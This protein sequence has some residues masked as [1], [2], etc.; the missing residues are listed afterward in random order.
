LEFILA[1][2]E[3]LKNIHFY[4]IDIEKKIDVGPDGSGDGV[5]LFFFFFC[6]SRF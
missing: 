3:I 2:N 4:G 6:E 1:V 5:F